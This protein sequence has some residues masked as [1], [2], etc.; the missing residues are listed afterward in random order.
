[1]G[2]LSGLPSP[3]GYA[4]PLVG[5]AA[6]VSRSGPRSVT[7]DLAIRPERIAIAG[8]TGSAM[9][10]NGSVPGP[11]V[12][13]YEGHDAVLR[14][15]NHL[16]K[17]SSIHWHGIL[18]PFE[19]DGVPGVTF[20][21]IAPGATF[22][23]RFPL[24]QSGTYWY[25]SHS[26]LQEQSG[27]YGPLV[28][29]PREPDPLVYD[30]DYIVMLSDWTFEDPHRVLARLKKMS[31]YY[32]FQRR[33]A[34]DFFRDASASGWGAT[35]SDRI[36]WGNMR[37]SPTDI[38]DVTG[39]T[40]TYLLNGLHPAGNWTGLFAPGER[41]R[42]RF[43]NGAAM[44][45]FNVRIPDL[46]MTVVAADG[47][48][49]EP[50]ETDEFQIGVAE[51]YDVIVEPRDRAYTVFAESL[52]RSGFA[53]GTLAPHDGMQAPVPP[54]RERPLRTMIDMGMDMRTHA[55]EEEASADTS[56]ESGMP[57]AEGHGA[58]G[59]SDGGGGAMVKAGPIVARH[60]P[61][62]HGAGNTTVAAVQRDR[63]A[64]RGTGLEEV[65]HRVLVYADLRSVGPR[66]MRPADRELEL[67]LTG[68]MERY[69]WSFDGKK[70][71]EVKS[72]IEF[73]YGERL[74]LTMVN[75]TMMEHPIHLHG[76]WMEL[77]N[78][79]G[80]RIPRKHTISI[81]PAE[82]LS[83][84]IDVDARGRAG[85]STVVRCGPSAVC[86]RRG[87]HLRAPRGDLRSL[88]DPANRRAASPRVR[89]SVQ[90]R[91]EVRRE[92]RHQRHRARSSPAIRDP[93]RDRPLPGRELASDARQHG[94]SGAGRG[95]GG[96]RLLDGVGPPLLVLTVECQP[97]LPTYRGSARRMR[98]HQT[99]R[100]PRSTVSKRR[101]VDVALVGRTRERGMR[102]LI[103]VIAILGAAVAAAETP[104]VEA[105]LEEAAAAA[106]ALERILREKHPVG[107]KAGGLHEKRATTAP[108][109]SRVAGEHGAS[110]DAHD[111]DDPT[112]DPDKSTP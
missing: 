8:G 19:M 10:I 103:V 91:R 34:G 86:E 58:H 78:G 36:A 57:M 27:V 12:E 1:M 84:L 21:G 63:L 39:Y 53:R 85:P 77:E 20:P 75:D 80:D 5:P 71:S 35:I 52:D 29:H 59:R 17:D 81:K 62:H 70:F 9:T 100:G 106:D 7:L 13:L 95:G 46:A 51:T 108:S 76:M 56:G 73:R 4:R 83:V 43:I 47:Q 64:E 68:N 67:H 18:L 26:G 3:P 96:R 31:D 93:A 25:H 49:V 92:G 24:V 40:Y 94:R 23:A 109:A 82:R 41:V 99:D 2:L 50:V 102:T 44:T 69:M 16:P 28:I 97:S 42:L 88:L 54:L 60:G 37:M 45:F 101:P 110:P 90:R 104:E 65:P 38:A 112:S 6:R 14:V 11:L 79:H 98:T 87:R 55:M 105:R 22:E 32:N 74:R 111:L 72:P 30:R 89:R 107:E 15:T 66:E 33:T 48:N 61:D